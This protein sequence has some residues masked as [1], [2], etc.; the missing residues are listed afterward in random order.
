[1]NEAIKKIFGLLQKDHPENIFLGDDIHMSSIAPYGVPT[2][3][4]ELDLYLGQRG[5]YPAGKIIELYGKPMC[6]KTTLALHAAAEWQKKGGIV[7]FIDTEFSFDPQRAT[8]LGCD[9]EA[10]IKAEAET[11]EG[12]FKYMIEMIDH[13]EK[14]AVTVP[15]LFIVDSATGVPTNADVKGDIDANER[16]GFE[17]KQIKRGIKKIN[18]KLCKIDSNPSIIFINH[19]V[20]RFVTFGKK[21]DSG[22]GNGIKFYAAVRICLSHIA[23]LKEKNTERRL[24]QKVNILIEKL[25]GACLEFDRFTTELKN[26]GGFDQYESLKLAMI[27][28]EFASRPKSSQIIT[29][30]PDTGYE[31][32]IKQKDFRDWV[33]QHGGYDA[34]YMTWRKWAI[35]NGVLSPWGTDK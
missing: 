3:L 30:L 12:V 6:G 9:A 21:S 11:I 23:T 16:P 1:M 31:S 29:F 2:G 8:Q 20:A 10:I 14:E 22:G 7:F 15:V 34:V 33:D 18:A 24:G 17:A 35:N 25:K 32:Q 27:A 5:G 28:T 13:L 19:A 4:A 26:D